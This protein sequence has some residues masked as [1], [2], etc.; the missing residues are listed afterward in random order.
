M[1]KIKELGL[2]YGEDNKSTFVLFKRFLDDIIKLF[3][4]TS[5]Q[6]DIFVEEI[7]QIHPPLKFTKCHKTLGS[8]IHV[9]V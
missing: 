7:K 4:G 3:T 9:L 2:K 6:L 5:K 8:W 1:N